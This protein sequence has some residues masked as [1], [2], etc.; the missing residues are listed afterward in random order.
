MPAFAGMTHIFMKKLEEPRSIGRPAE[1]TKK[2][3]IRAVYKLC[4][5]RYVKAKEFPTY[6]Y[7]LCKQFCGS[8]RAAKWEAKVIHGSRW[9]YDKFIKWVYQFAKNKYREEKDWPAKM[10]VLAKRFCGSVR[11]AK[12][13]AGVIRDKRH[14]LRGRYQLQGLWTKKRFLKEFT[15]ICSNGYKKPSQVPGYMRTLAVQHCGSVRAAKWE[16]GILKD[17]RKA[18]RV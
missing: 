16:C 3:A 18:K 11:R 2:D 17:I 12:W 15:V 13:E 7:K 5:G 4:K 6:L 14:R 1:W 10:R 8:V 9:T